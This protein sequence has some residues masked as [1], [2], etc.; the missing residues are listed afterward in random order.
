[1]HR[2]IEHQKALMDSSGLGLLPG[3]GLAFALV[4]IVMAALVLEQWWITF[5]VLGCLFLA[6]GAVVWVVLKVMSDEEGR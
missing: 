1:M 5:S 6:T 4:L 3:I 2:E